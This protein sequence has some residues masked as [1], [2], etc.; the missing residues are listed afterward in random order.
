VPQVTF[1][2]PTTN[3]NRAVAV[4]EQAWVNP[5]N[6]QSVAGANPDDGV[7][8]TGAANAVGLVPLGAT[9]WGT[10]NLLAAEGGV[11]SYGG[12]VGIPANA[13]IQTVTTAWEFSTAAGTPTFFYGERVDGV[14]TESSL[15]GAAALAVRTRTPAGLTVA[16]LDNA[17]FEMRARMTNSNATTVSTCALDYV[18]VTVTWVVFLDKAGGALRASAAGGAKTALVSGKVAGGVSPAAAGA[19][20]TALVSGK[21]GGATVTQSRAGATR[22]ALLGKAG[23]AVSPASASAARTALI[24]KL[25]GAIAAAGAGGVERTSQPA[26]SGVTRS[27]SGAIV[28]GARVDIFRTDTKAFLASVTS[29]ASTGAYVYGTSRLIP[30][31]FIRSF[32]AGS[33]NVFGT[34]DEDLLPEEAQVYGPPL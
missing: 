32:K 13:T 27:G 16:T 6:A 17:S 5:A 10:F 31:F 3:V 4:T 9:D 21:A 7:T 25:V 2:F 30:G 28:G 34:T 11:P 18:K 33:P 8:A 22:T 14:V 19:A 20:K 26:L 23:G 1:R 15:A 29:D 12:G 24:A